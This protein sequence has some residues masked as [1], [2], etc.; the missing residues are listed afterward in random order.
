MPDSH[1]SFSTA[2]RK[3]IH[4]NKKRKKKERKKLCKL[5]GEG[6]Q[7]V[8]DR[9]EH[10][11]DLKGCLVFEQVRMDKV[12]ADKA[13]PPI[14]LLHPLVSAALAL[15]KCLETVKSTAPTGLFTQRT[16]N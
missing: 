4:A 15:V 13:T 1:S 7:L 8:G 14:T 16:V 3:V 9:K 12:I 5:L 2:K 11:P 10:E 6:T